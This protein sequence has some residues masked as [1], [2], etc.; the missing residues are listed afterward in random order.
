MVE[1][2]EVAGHLDPEWDDL[3]ASAARVTRFTWHKETKSGLWHS[4]EEQAFYVCQTGLRAAAFAAAIRGHW[5]IENRSHHVRDVTFLEDGSRIRT[6][7]GHFA[8]FRSFALNLLRANGINNV[9]QELYA[10]A[11]NIDNLLSYRV[12]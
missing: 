4:T 11:L 2:F 1:V 8:R 12:T 9:S 3:I 5:G 10:N 6:K 7:P